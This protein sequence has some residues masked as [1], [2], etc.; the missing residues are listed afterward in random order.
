MVTVV[1]VS[2]VVPSGACH[3]KQSRILHLWTEWRISIRAAE[4]HSHQRKRHEKKT[5]KRYC[6]AKG[7][8][9]RWVG[10]GKVESQGTRLDIFEQQGKTQFVL[11]R[12]NQYEIPMAWPLICFRSL[13]TGMSKIGTSQTWRPK[14]LADCQNLTPVASGWVLF[15]VFCS[16]CRVAKLHMLTDCKFSQECWP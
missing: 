6:H 5:K 4:S 16:N 11:F 2:M 13:I 9:K 14:Q 12:A 15:F 1:V 7:N 10:C 3:L 8:A